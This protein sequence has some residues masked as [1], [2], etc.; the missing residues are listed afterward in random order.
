MD[1]HRKVISSVDD[2]STV[3]LDG[4]LALV[5]VAPCVARA[6]VIMNSGM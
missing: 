5:C 3:L 2:I 1:R 4:H 6:R